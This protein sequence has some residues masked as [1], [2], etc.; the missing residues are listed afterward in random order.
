MKNFRYLVQTVIVLILL[1]AR[2]T[3]AQD[4]DSSKIALPVPQMAG[5]W[6]GNAYDNVIAAP[7][8]VTLTLVQHK[9]TIAGVW[10][11]E[12]KNCN[13]FDLVESGTLRG[14]VR[15]VNAVP[16]VGTLT[17]TVKIMSTNSGQRHPCAIKM[18]AEM[19]LVGTTVLEIDGN[20]LSCKHEVGD[21]SLLPG[22]GNGQ[23][24]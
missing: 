2:A 9:N 4:E 15:W 5:T 3:L 1:M 20:Y 18:R 7:G 11:A 14:S 10:K 6:S 13:N 23:S 19:P 22:A 17:A 12:F 16:P 21:F 24:C 8:I